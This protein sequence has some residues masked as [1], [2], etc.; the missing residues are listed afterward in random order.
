[1][2]QVLA[3]AAGFIAVFCA[4]RWVRREYERVETSLRRM[5]RHIR[6]A[7]PAGTPLA[8]DAA[9]GFYRLAEQGLPKRERTIRSIGSQAPFRKRLSDCAGSL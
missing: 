3:I 9:R 1:M 5:E 7:S 8:F 2:L 4:L 6:R